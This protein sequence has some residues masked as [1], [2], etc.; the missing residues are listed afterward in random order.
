MAIV[1]NTNVN[2]LIVQR[3]LNASTNGMATAMERMTTGLRINSAAD[4]AAGLVISKG[5][6]TQ[7]RG[8]EMAIKN[9]Q[10]GINML[11]TAEGNL[12]KIQEHL[13][14]IRDLTLQAMNGGYS[15]DEVKAMESE[16][17]ARQNEIDRIATGAKFNEFDL[18]AAGKTK[19]DGVT[20]QIGSGSKAATN[21]IEV[22]G[23]FHDAQ[24]STLS[25]GAAA[26]IKGA[27]TFVDSGGAVKDRSAI[28]TDVLD[29]IDVAIKDVSSRLGTIGASSIRLNAAVDNL[30]VQSQNLQAANSRIKDADI[31]QESSN[32]LNKQIL[33]QAGAALLAQAN[34]APSVALS[35]I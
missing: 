2:S 9:A 34:Q 3:S 5:I 18:F 13:L 15:A 12:D 6:E 30:S 1:I 19:T 17:Q 26:G 8:T 7:Q 11:Q 10:N 32:Y 27:I 16:V 28:A 23:V 20:Y 33:Q 4:D 29:K 21:T 31:A 22:K 14:A 24:L 25:G 35:L